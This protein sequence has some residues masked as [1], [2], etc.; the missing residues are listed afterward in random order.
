[1]LDEIIHQTVRLKVMA[2][3]VAVD[4]DV[5]I[6]FSFLKRL[7]QLTDGNLGAHLKKLEDAGYIRLEK[8]ESDR[9]VR[10]LLSATAAG[11]KAYHAHI[12]ALKA[13]IDGG[14]GEKL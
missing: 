11:R 10:S 2:A 1:M 14:G 8:V 6:D 12:R 3:L 5:D 4:E 13:I 7:L 9:R